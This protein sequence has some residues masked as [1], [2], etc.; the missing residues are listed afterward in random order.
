MGVPGALIC[1]PFQGK[2]KKGNKQMLVDK[3]IL[4]PL[5]ESLTF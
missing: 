1:L 4:V 2:K 3:E 5:A